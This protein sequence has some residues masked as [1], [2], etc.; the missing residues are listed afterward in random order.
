MIFVINYLYRAAVAGISENKEEGHF[1]PSISASGS[2]DRNVPSPYLQILPDSI[3]NI[4]V[5]IP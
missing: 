5:R 4:H 2:R 3:M 1:S